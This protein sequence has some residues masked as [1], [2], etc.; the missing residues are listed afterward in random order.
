VA[1]LFGGK[2]VEHEVS[3]ISGVQ[4]M[5]A[6]DETKY[7]V[8][9]VYITK[10]NEFYTGD[11][12][13]DIAA[14]RDMPALVAAASRARFE[15]DGSRTYLVSGEAGLLKKQMRRL[16]DVAMPVV[17]GTNV[18]DGALQG[19]LETLN[20]PYCGPDVLS[21]AICMDKYVM[22][23][24][25]QHGGFPVLPGLRLSASDDAVA[26]VENAFAYPVIVKP[27]NLGSS[28][29]I[30][31]AA[32]AAELRDC[33]ETALSFARYAVVEPAVVALRE[34]NCSVLGDAS[35]AVA[36]ECEEP[37]MHD[38]ILSYQDKYGSGGKAGPK[39]GVGAKGMASAQRQIPAP[40]TPEQRE[41]I[42]TL[43]VDAFRY[44]G[45]AGVSR[46]DFLM[47][48][49]TGDIW[50]NELNT[51]PGS[52]SFYLWEAVDMSYD[53]LLDRL[54]E[55]ALKRAR[56][57]ADITYAFDSNILANVSLGTKH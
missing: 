33:V 21:S 44:L 45:C 3:I 30:G 36:S 10:A 19:Y 43:A 50:I 20:L 55:I 18:E 8:I 38:A 42:R 7:D 24:M 28:V 54:I 52:L 23:I 47:D 22:K 6:L 1:V 26:S 51:I 11:H 56:E 17:H 25:L 15:V 5:L 2:S 53:K 29:G 41:H 40:V 31:K 39:A 34:I 12:L 4:A 13:K 46:V 16:V 32:N 49:N 37:V 57:A 27:V 14:Y 48:A 35:D 9:P